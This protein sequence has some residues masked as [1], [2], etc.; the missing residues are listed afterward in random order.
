MFFIMCFCF[1][2]RDSHITQLAAVCGGEK[3]STYILPR[4]P[5]TRKASEITGIEVVNG[6]MFCRNKEVNAVNISDGLDAFLNFLSTFQTKVI[7]VG[8]NIKSYD[9]HLLL[10]ALESCNRTNF[11]SQHVEGFVDTK[12]LFKICDSSLKCYT[13]ESLFKHFVSSEYNVHDALEDVLA[14]QKLIRHLDIDVS[15]C[16]FSDVSFTFL[17][18]F[19]CWKY[20]SEVR[21]NVPTLNDLISKHVVSKG[22]ANKIAGSGLN[23]SCL[24]LAY[25]RNPHDGIYNLLSEKV[26]NSIRVTKSQRVIHSLNKYFATL[27]EI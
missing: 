1:P 22:M 11:V 19:E 9:C 27:C 21:K 14:L 23:F 12:I 3:F 13:Q 18:A 2:A 6:K 20:C 7:L 5:I 24:K 26:R 15:A 8:H 16:I 17:N 4:K 25:T 10:N